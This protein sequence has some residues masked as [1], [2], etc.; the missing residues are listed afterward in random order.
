MRVVSLLASAT[1]IVCALGA[2]DMLVGRSHECDNPDWVR[3]LPRCSEPAFDTTGASRAIDAEVRRRLREGEPL[4]RIH[5]DLIR[6]L[7]PD[8]VIAQT[9]CE[10]CAVTPADVTR[11]G[12]CLTD[13][14]MLVLSVVSV[15]DDLG[16]IGSVAGALGL[17]AHG[18]DGADAECRRFD[19]VRS[20]TGRLPHPTV[21]L[22]EWTDP[23]FAM[24]NWMPEIV[25]IAGGRP[26]LAHRG[27]FSTTVSFEQLA[28]ADP[29][30]VIVAPCG[31]SLERALAERGVLE[32]Y[33]G[34]RDL[35][36]VRQGAVAVADGNRFFNRSGMTVS[37]TAE[38]L[39][40][41]LHGRGFGEGSFGGYW[42]WL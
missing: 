18:R 42:Q 32:A 34:W 16:G 5:D 26:L 8:L 30:V 1:E 41:I 21:A 20:A 10:V 4:Y 19:A 38:L 40:E 6:S 17:G 7:R 2:G 37:Q 11:D 29:D 31:F 24:G 28:A 35:R 3:A 9:H 22:L 27:E 33:P 39:A 36:A 15:D 12:A 23:L 14:R 13:C 25:A